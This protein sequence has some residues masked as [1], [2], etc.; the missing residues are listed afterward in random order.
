MADPPAASP[1][2]EPTSALPLRWGAYRTRLL[3][4]LLLV[5]SGGIAFGG[6]A[7]TTPFTS[8][9]LAAG[10][11]AHLTGWLVLPAA[12]W[13]RIWALAPSAI[14]VVFLLP[15]PRWAW[16][17]VLP[18]L[19][20]LLV[21]HRPLASFPTAIIVVAGA[22]LAGRFFGQEYAG[23]LP[24]LAVVGAVIVA[25]AWAARAV[26]VAQSRPRRGGGEPGAGHV[27]RARKPRQPAA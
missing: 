26:H 11:V 17:L 21:R 9:L 23:M 22:V 27:R 6:G 1:W 19:G 13:R 25:S 4:G 10:M 7:G 18:Y 2:R 5:V 3:G 8:A 12:G 14:S 15:G 24:T 16:T 20:W